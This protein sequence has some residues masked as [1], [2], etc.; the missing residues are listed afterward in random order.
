MKK[1]T[2]AV[3]HKPAIDHRQALAE[4]QR[5]PVMEENKI[6]CNKVNSATVITQTLEAPNNQQISLYTVQNNWYLLYPE[7][8]FFFSVAKKEI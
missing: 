5:P 4:Y 8:L 1:E 6:G 2:A 3:V 7:H